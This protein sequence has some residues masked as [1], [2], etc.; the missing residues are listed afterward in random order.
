MKEEIPKNLQEIYDK[1]SDY[2]DS[3]CYTSDG[4]K[5][6]PDEN[7]A[8]LCMNLFADPA[9]LVKK[10][11]D[12][13]NNWKDVSVSRESV[14][15]H[16]DAADKS[17]TVVSL[18][19]GDDVLVVETGLFNAVLNDTPT[20]SNLFGQLAKHRGTNKHYYVF[21]YDSQIDKSFPDVNITFL[22]ANQ[23]TMQFTASKNHDILH[24]W[25]LD[26]AIKVKYTFANVADGIL[27][28][29][30]YPLVLSVDAEISLV[31]LSSLLDKFDSGN[32]YYYDFIYDCHNRDS[33]FKT[34]EIYHSPGSYDRV[35]FDIQGQS[36]Y[37][38]YLIPF[39]E[40][41]AA[42]WKKNYT[43]EYLGLTPPL[44]NSYNVYLVRRQHPLLHAAYC[45]DNY[46]LINGADADFGVV[47]TIPPSSTP[48]IDF[49]PYQL[50]IDIR[51]IQPED[52]SLNRNNRWLITP[53][54]E[55]TFITYSDISVAKNVISYRIHEQTGSVRYRKHGINNSGIKVY[56]LVGV[57]ILCIITPK[58]TLP[59][60]VAVLTPYSIGYNVRRTLEYDLGINLHLN[61]RRWAYL[62]FQNYRSILNSKFNLSQDFWMVPHDYTRFATIYVVSSTRRV[63]T[64]VQHYSSSSTSSSLCAAV[65]VMT[66]PFQ[67]IENNI[68][69]YPHSIAYGK[70][71]STHAGLSGLSGSLYPIWERHNGLFIKD[72]PPSFKELVL[73]PQLHAAVADS[74]PLPIHNIMSMNDY[75]RFLKLRRVLRFRTKFSISTPSSYF[76]R[77][78]DGDDGEESGVT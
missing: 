76:V 54:Q 32:I 73:S 31:F 21:P 45:S 47:N 40:I 39:Y 33:V 26:P 20:V 61:P 10:Q 43:L 55:G 52:Y 17:S 62:D 28:C 35:S 22:S 70:L 7:A 37:Q 12:T 16:M 44:S 2:I 4:K 11:V 50:P 38:L 48:E 1:T 46:A 23:R 57:K 15:S 8:Q 30:P 29:A 67:V 41:L 13:N 36:S 14:D 66:S 3:L 65:T 49:V 9:P 71:M 27:F 68:R 75:I 60:I 63:L 69:S 25:H 64:T 56:D 72:M 74:Y 18:T 77:K 19:P 78:K 51:P 24:P 42:F 59:T 6:D 5:F 58:N 53:A 34:L